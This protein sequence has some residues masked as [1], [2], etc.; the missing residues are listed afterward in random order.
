M[1]VTLLWGLGGFL[2]AQ[3]ALVFVAN[4]TTSDKDN[5][6]LPK[7]YAAVRWLTS[8]NARVAAAAGQWVR[9]KWLA[10]RARRKS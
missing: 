10:W 6:F 3:F 4:L 5:A 8:A 2:V 7:V 1:L 9:E